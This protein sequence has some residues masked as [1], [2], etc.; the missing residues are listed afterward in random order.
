MVRVAL[1]RAAASFGRVKV[2]TRITVIDRQD[3]SANQLLREAFDPFQG[4]EIHFRLVRLVQMSGDCVEMQAQLCICNWRRDETESIAGLDY[5]SFL[6]AGSGAT[7]QVHGHRIEKLIGEMDAAERLD[8]DQRFF[9]FELL[10]E[11]T[12]RFRLPLPQDWKWFDDPIAKRGEKIRGSLAHSSEN[13][14]GEFAMVG[15]LFDD[16]EI[17]GPAK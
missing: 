14:L 4:R 6:P 8:I 12:E 7:D 16:D 1:Q 13:I 11:I 15:P 17:I 2:V 5:T 9:P 3:I 10:A